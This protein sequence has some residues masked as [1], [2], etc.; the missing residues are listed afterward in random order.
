M[1]AENTR[2]RRGWRETVEPGIYRAHKLSCPSS[3]DR[4]AGRRCTCG[5]QFKA[6]GFGPGE[7]RL[8]SHPGP[9]AAARAER[10][11]LMA[12]G[13]LERSVEPE[14]VSDIVTVRD[15]AQAYLRANARV[16]APSTVH[17]YEQ[18]YRTGVDPLLGGVQLAEL[19]RSRV[20]A[21]LAE[22]SSTRS[23][24]W[25]WKA[26]T[27]LRSV[28]KFGV[29]SGLIEENPAAGLR[30]PKSGA[31]DSARMGA[32]RVVTMEQLQ[33]LI[34]ACPDVRTE[35]MIRVSAEAGLR[36]GEMIGLRWSDLDLHARRATIARSVWQAP[37]RRGEPPTHHVK[38]PKNGRV[39]VVALSAGLAERLADLF[40]IEVIEKGGAADGYVFPGQHGKPLDKYA[41]GRILGRTCKRAGLVDAHG[42][43]LISWHGLRHTCASLMFAAGVPLPDVSAQLRHSNPA[44]TAKVYTHSLGEDR[45]HAAASIFDAQTA[46]ETVRGVGETRETSTTAGDSPAERADF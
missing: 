27:A 3:S 15:L 42:K 1:H 2:A 29:S 11:R 8:V 9:V 44:I 25:V 7:T 36:A 18:A 34:A 21:W 19:T 28:C 16:L 39:A 14:P 33:G 43:A 10:R 38:K 24:H 41:P 5:F 17:F 6:P 32:H 12:A 37:G 23:D 4:K 22:I 46:R 31:D 13:R 26:H 30:L 35:A 45:Q 20:V 40:A